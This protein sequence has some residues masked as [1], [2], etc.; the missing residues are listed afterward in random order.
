MTA[1]LER[2]AAPAARDWT[3]A[4]RDGERLSL[5]RVTRD[6]AP[7]LVDLL[8]RLSGRSLAL[9]YHAPRQLSLDDAWREAERICAGHRGIQVALVAVAP[10]ARGD[11][12]VAVAELVPDASEPATGH[13]AVVVR[14]DYQA[15][16]IGTALLRHLLEDARGG[17]LTALRADHLA[18]N[19]AAR[20]LL[21]RLGLPAT[22]RTRHGVV[23]VRAPLVSLSNIPAR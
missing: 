18:E 4:T 22:A 19:T 12:I 2:P 7:A 1:T 16:G 21:D 14:D 23:E 6:D 17:E 10:L 5:R 15:R 13:L 3:F 11:E 9:R 8:L 20:R